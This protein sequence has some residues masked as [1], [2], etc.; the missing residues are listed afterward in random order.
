MHFNN[1]FANDG[2][3]KEGPERY[4]KMTTGNTSQIKQWIWNLKK[5]NHEYH[6]TYNPQEHYTT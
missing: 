1:S 5:I 3:S 2:G 6:F 4:Q